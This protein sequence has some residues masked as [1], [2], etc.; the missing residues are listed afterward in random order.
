MA[1]VAYADVIEVLLNR[2]PEFVET[3]YYDMANADLAYIVWAGFGS[4]VTD[5][6]RELPADRLDG[7]P[8][9]ARVFDLANELMDSDDPNTRTIVVVELFEHFYMY[10]KT[11]ELA[12]RKLKPEHLP[13]LEGLSTGFR[14]PEPD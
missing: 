5:Y 4:Y 8:F 12:R 10:W 7:D 9:V 3:E 2:F 6:M 14:T 13:S 11:L 1:G